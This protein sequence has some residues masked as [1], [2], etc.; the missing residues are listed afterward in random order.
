MKYKLYSS[1][2]AHSTSTSKGTVSNA[3]IRSSRLHT[4][5]TCIKEA[6]EGLE[7][8]APA[9]GVCGTILRE[10]FSGPCIGL[11]LGATWLAFV[12]PA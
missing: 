12:W 4:Y 3:L 1:L 9:Q 8:R 5:G 2:N 7:Q 11:R 10:L 6:L